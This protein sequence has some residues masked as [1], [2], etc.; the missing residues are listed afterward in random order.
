MIQLIAFG[1]DSKAGECKSWDAT[2]GWGE[3]DSLPVEYLAIQR[4]LV[5]L[6]FWLRQ[7]IGTAT[8]LRLRGCER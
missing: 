5:R 3:R 1:T 2:A 7:L 4:K 6:R 8:R